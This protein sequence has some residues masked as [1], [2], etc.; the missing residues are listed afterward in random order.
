M[1][2]SSIGSA[3]KEKRGDGLQRESRQ[4]TATFAV[5][6][7]GNNF[8]EWEEREAEQ[9]DAVSERVSSGLSDIEVAPEWLD[10][11]EDQEEEE[12][13]EDDGKGVLLTFSYA[14]KDWFGSIFTKCGEETGTTLVG[15]SVCYQN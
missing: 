10:T 5:E 8:N 9:I 12:E 6:A 7:R 3:W 1:G 4:L 11:P 14:D 15:A 13:E 2:S